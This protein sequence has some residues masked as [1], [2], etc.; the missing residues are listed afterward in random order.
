[1][2]N[3]RAG[4][5]GDTPIIGAGNYADDRACAVSCTGTGE[6]FIRHAAAFRV[7]ALMQWAGRDLPSAAE[8][9]IHRTLS[10]GD[11]GLIA[12]DRAG[13]VAMPF[14]TQGMFRAAADARGWS[15]VEI[16]A[17][18]LSRERPQRTPPRPE[19]RCLFNVC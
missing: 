19:M 6:Q 13:N 9:V 12:V 11:G 7:A 15:V 5:V 8:E 16:R 4:R 3:K 17:G 1:M 14:N 10:P 18:A 2:T